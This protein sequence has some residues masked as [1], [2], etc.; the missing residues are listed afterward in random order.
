[1]T[2]SPARCRINGGPRAFTLVEML[3]AIAIIA[4]LLSLTLVAGSGVL[5][6]TDITR[7]Q[8]TIQ[9]L[10]LALSE[11]SAQADRRLSWGESHAPSGGPAEWH[12]IYG[13]IPHVFTTTEALRVAARTEA[14]RELLATLDP[15]VLVVLDPSET[16]PL[17]LQ[18]VASDPNDPDPSSNTVVS[19]FGSGLPNPSGPPRLF[20]E[21]LAV[22]DAWGRPI[23]MVHPGRTWRRGDDALIPRDE[24]GTIR[25]EMEEIYGICRGREPYFVSAGRSGR[26]GDLSSSDEDVRKLS[27]DNLYSYPVETRGIN[28]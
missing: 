14:V 21:Q 20:D 5:R 18:Q 23:R 13:D 28:R 19:V 6:R 25:T 12:D 15:Q 7:T 27:A 16:A 2:R 11:W 17:W 26:F 9:V 4:I 24:D 10:D 1:M 8:R 3:V 22:L